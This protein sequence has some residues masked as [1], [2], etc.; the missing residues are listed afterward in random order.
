MAIY[1]IVC[2]KEIYD[3]DFDENHFGE[4]E[5][6]RVRAKSLEEAIEKGKKKAREMQEK[7]DKHNFKHHPISGPIAAF[8]E[9]IINNKNNTVYYKN[10]SEIETY[11]ITC[12]E[13]SYNIASN[14]R[15]FE[16][17]RK[18]TI[19]AESLEEAI[20][21]GKKK[22]NEISQKLDEYRVEHKLYCGPF[23]AYLEKVRDSN[24][25]L[26]YYDNLKDH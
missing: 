8:L 13:Q 14:K 6:F 18:S 24:G 4:R 25:N 20:E 19:H 26:V 16:E 21:K 3:A 22:A 1:T 15:T 23:T 12:A 10:T 7:I 9:K 5:N 2:I 17:R 11:T